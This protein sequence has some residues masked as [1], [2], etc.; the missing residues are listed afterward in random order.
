[1][2]YYENVGVWSK[3]TFIVDQSGDLNR[4]D[5]IP[6][7]RRTLPRVLLSFLPSSPRR[8]RH[9]RQRGHQRQEQLLRKKDRNYF[10]QFSSFIEIFHENLPAPAPD[11][12]LEHNSLM[13]TDSQH[14]AKSPGQKGST[15]TLAAFKMVLI[16]SA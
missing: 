10:L 8:E 16:F 12:T 13:S 1:M 14:L 4:K 5:R 11:P 6:C 15:S 7:R 3:N 9:L 2:K